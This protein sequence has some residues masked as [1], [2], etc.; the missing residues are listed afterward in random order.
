MSAQYASA[1]DSAGPEFLTVSEV[2]QALRVSK[3]TVYRMIRAHEI[4]AARFGKSYR[5]AE[6][7]VADYIRHASTAEEGPAS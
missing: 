5:I 6:S 4:P 7:A 1:T 2:A 3:M